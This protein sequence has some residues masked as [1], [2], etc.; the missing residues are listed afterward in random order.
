MR[1]IGFVS[2]A[3]IVKVTVSHKKLLI[4]RK[5]K[6]DIPLCVQKENLGRKVCLSR[7]FLDLSL[8]ILS[9]MSQETFSCLN[10]CNF[11]KTILMIGLES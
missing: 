9:Q 5:G 4:L 1:D 7:I 11:I 3:K 8:N 2:R 6:N 10:Y